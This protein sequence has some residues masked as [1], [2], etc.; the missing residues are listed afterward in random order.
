MATALAGLAEADRRLEA[1]STAMA[2]AQ[3][4]DLQRRLAEYDRA[5]ATFERQGGYGFVGRDTQEFRRLPVLALC[6]QS[7]YDVST[8]AWRPLLSGSLSYAISTGPLFDTPVPDRKA[9][10]PGQ[11]Q[12]SPLRAIL[13]PRRSTPAPTRSSIALGAPWMTCP[14]PTTDG[15]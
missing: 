8:M 15:L 6:Q 3:G 10:S 5:L 11:Q 9:E 1:L 12:Y 13:S 2:S 4:D 14:M 7:C